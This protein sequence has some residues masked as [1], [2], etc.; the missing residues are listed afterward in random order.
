MITAVAYRASWNSSRFD[1]VR[2]LLQAVLLTALIAVAVVLTIALVT[3]LTPVVVGCCSVAVAV[4]P[5]AAIV[6]AVFY[7]AWLVKP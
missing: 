4:A 2:A 5:K 1:A 6:A 3:M 7:G